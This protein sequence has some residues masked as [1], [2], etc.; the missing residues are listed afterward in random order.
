MGL[1]VWFRDDITAALLAADQASATTVAALGDGT[2]NPETIRAFRQGFRAALATVALAF[3]L[4][5]KNEE[6]A[7]RCT[8]G[9]APT[10]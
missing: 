7:A 2:V 8:L 3:G 6:W 5:P 10:P 1:D 9:D 4:E